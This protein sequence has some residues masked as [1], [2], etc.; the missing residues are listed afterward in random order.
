M[1]WTLRG[2][3]LLPADLDEG[4]Q[5]GSGRP[6][7]P[8]VSEIQAATTTAGTRAQG[9]LTPD[10]LALS[11]LPSFSSCRS[12]GVTGGNVRL[13]NRVP[14]DSDANP[15]RRKNGTFNCSLANPSLICPR[16]H[17]R[18]LWNRLRI[19]PARVLLVRPL[20]RCFVVIWFDHTPP[21]PLLP[22]ASTGHPSMASLQSA[23]S[24]GVVG[25]LNT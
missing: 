11:T 14:G 16:L 3:H 6:V 2:A 12:S 17:L 8:L 10:F 4:P 5:R 25:C 20:L 15:D 13:L 7:P 19:S 23:S 21:S 9:G 24:S 1:Q 18:R 22:I